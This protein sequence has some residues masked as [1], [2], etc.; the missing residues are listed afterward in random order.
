MSKLIKNGRSFPKSVKVAT[1]ATW[2]GTTRSAKV[3]SREYNMSESTVSRWAGDADLQ[4]GT[5]HPNLKAAVAAR[6]AYL[7]TTKAWNTP[8]VVDYTTKTGKTAQGIQ[9]KGKLYK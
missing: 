2:A 4:R 5:Q 6:I 3:I 7:A 1:L 8:T 9:L